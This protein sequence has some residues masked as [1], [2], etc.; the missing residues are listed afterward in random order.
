[1]KYNTNNTIL[2]GYLT[3]GSTVKIKLINTL[4]DKL[5]SITDDVCI[6]SEHIGGLFYFDTSKIDEEF[7]SLEIAYVMSDNA[8]EFYGGK[9]VISNDVPTV[10]TIKKDLE[11]VCLGNWRLE[12]NQYIIEGVDGTEIARFNTFDAAGNPN[13][14]VIY[15]RER[16]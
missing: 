2:C 13:M 14:R 12:D 6:E 1:M 5:I 10:S 15:S 16:V 4:T 8:G 3:A 7:V 11:D 9:V